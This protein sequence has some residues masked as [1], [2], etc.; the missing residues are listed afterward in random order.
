VNIQWTF[1][2]HSVNIQCIF[3]EHSVKIQCTFCEHSVEIQWT[4]SK[5]SGNIQ[6]TFREHSVN[7]Q[8]KFREHSERVERTPVSLHPNCKKHLK[9]STKVDAEHNCQ[10]WVPKTRVNK[11]KR[12]IPGVELRVQCTFSAHSGNIQW[13]FTGEKR[14]GQV[15]QVCLSWHSYKHIQGTCRER[16]GNIQGTFRK[17]DT[18]FAWC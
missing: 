11:T 7:I 5:H 18:H 3:R 14:G 2:E 8:W 17:Q 15:C 16:A 10:T 9:K 4:F 6:C 1:S 12:S 13:K